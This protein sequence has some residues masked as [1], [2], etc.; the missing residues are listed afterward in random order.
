MAAKKSEISESGPISISTAEW[1]VMELLWEQS[2]QGSP[3]ICEALAVSHGWK[4]ATVMTLLRRL[5]DKGAVS[6]TGNAKRWQYAPA[7]D[8]DHCV[9]GETRG[10]LDKLFQGALLPMVAH[11]LEHQKLSKKEI[12]DLRAMLE[13]AADTRKR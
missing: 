4:R 3:E 13:Q 7:V 12:Q 6:S 11:C 10:F 2:P 9:A 5:M 8:R 1:A